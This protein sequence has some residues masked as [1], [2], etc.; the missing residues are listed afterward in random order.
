MVLSIGAGAL[1]GF[2]R[3]FCLS[4][5]ATALG[6]AAAFTLG[7]YLLA[8]MVASYVAERFPGYPAIETALAKEGWKLVFLLKV[9]PFCPWCVLQGYT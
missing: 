4:W 1:F 9:A 2:V 7:R 8:D 5:A 3:G 6:T